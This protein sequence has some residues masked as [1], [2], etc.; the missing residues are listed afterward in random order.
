MQIGVAVPNTTTSPTFRPTLGGVLQT[1]HPIMKF[2]NG[3]YIAVAIG[4]VQGV[5]VL[6]YDLPNTT[7][8][9]MSPQFAQL[10]GSSTQVFNVA[11]ATLAGHAVRLSQIS[12]ATVPMFSA[13]QSA[14][15]ALASN[16]FSIIQLQ[17]KE[18]DTVTA[19]NNTASPATL[20]GYTVP[21]YSFMPTVTGYYQVNCAASI[22]TGATQLTASIYKTGSRFKDGANSIAATAQICA[23]VEFQSK[24]PL[25]SHR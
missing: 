23:S 22:A 16:A 14:L 18:W 4:D 1:A 5:A 25:P 19:F 21:A 10:A 11:A 13:Y 20:N 7:W 6:S 24:E 8:E 2:V 15:Q 9:L 12:S 3:A 17:T